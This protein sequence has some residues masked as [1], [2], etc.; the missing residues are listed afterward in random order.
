ME[1][2]TDVLEGINIG[3]KLAGR[4]LTFM[5]SGEEY[6]VE[7]TRVLQ[8]IQIEPITM[9]PRTPE[10]IRGVIN[11]RGK[12]IPIIDLRL[13]FEMSI[14]EDT[15]KTCIIVLQIGTLSTPFTIG[16]IIDEVR[17]VTQISAEQ[18]EDVPSFGGGIDV[19][20]LMG[21]AKDNDNVRM[22]IDIDKLFSVSELEKIGDY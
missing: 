8:I 19:S 7:I 20:F 3:E 5:L 14:Q 9:V 6:S 4:Y 18:I 16:V 15:E 17:E 12:V 2:E 10:H 22:I 21:M 13:K 11:L 1:K